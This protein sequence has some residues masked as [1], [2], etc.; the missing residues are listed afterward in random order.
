MATSKC[1][2]LPRC[3]TAPSCECV[4]AGGNPV[5]QQQQRP[6]PRKLAAN[7]SLTGEAPGYWCYLKYAE[8]PGRPGCDRAMDS[9]SPIVRAGIT[10]GSK[11]QIIHPSAHTWTEPRMQLTE[12]SASERQTFTLPCA[13]DAASL[14]ALALVCLFSPLRVLTRGTHGSSSVPNQAM[15]TV[16]LDRGGLCWRYKRPCGFRTVAQYR[17]SSQLLSSCCLLDPSLGNLSPA[18]ILCW[19]MQIGKLFRRS[20]GSTYLLPTHEGR[21]PDSTHNTPA[22]FLST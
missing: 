1:R 6:L 3:A 11:A 2:W 15:E 17:A 16:Q 5:L 9:L 18:Y 12:W 19:N 20:T 21:I 8:D 14:A 4:L 13:H 22:T 10:G 7:A